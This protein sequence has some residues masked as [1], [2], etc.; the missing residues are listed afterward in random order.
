MMA[1]GMACGGDTQEGSEATWGYDESTEEEFDTASYDG[2]WCTRGDDEPVRSYNTRF[3]EHIG[4]ALVAQ[5]FTQE[6]VLDYYLKGLADSS[7]LEGMQEGELAT[8]DGAMEAAEEEELRQERV[9]AHV[10]A[11]KHGRPLQSD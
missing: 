7:L 1:S 4:P 3:V 11:Y 5:G 2:N 6:E 9:A 10:A 8:L